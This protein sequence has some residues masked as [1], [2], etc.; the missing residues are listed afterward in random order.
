MRFPFLAGQLFA[1]LTDSFEKVLRTDNSNDREYVSNSVPRPLG[2]GSTIFTGVIKPGVS[3][4][5][6]SALEGF[7]TRDLGFSHSRGLGFDQWR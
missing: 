4:S 5:R 3:L 2:K 6:E 1:V 7:H